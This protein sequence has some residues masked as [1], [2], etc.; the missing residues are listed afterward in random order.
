[1][2]KLM[3]K[4]RCRTGRHQWHPIRVQGQ[5]GRECSVCHERSFDRPPGLDLENYE[6]NKGI[7]GGLGGGDG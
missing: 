6:A 3:N 1:M 2:N 4:I 5:D 7:L